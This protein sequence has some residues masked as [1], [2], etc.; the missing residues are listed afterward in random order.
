MCPTACMGTTVQLIEIGI[1]VIGIR[2]KCAL[3]VTK[4]FLNHL[5]L[6][7]PKQVIADLCR[8]VYNNPHIALHIFEGAVRLFH[9]CINPSLIDI[10]CGSLLEKTSL[11]TELASFKKL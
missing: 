4:E 10:D 3:E 7:A 6:P 2:H 11:N 8:Q 5:T 1:C 9:L